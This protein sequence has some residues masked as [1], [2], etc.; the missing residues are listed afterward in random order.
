[1][2]IIVATKKVFSEVLYVLSNN[3]I[4]ACIIS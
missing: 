4:N 1:L 2:V 3:Q